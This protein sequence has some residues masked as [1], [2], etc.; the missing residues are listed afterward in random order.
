MTLNKLTIKQAQAKMEAG[1]ISS[2]DLTEACLARIKEI[3]DDVKACL[4]VCE[5]D[6]LEEARVADKRRAK[7][8]KGSL[9]GIPYLA[10]DNI[11]GT[12][13]RPRVK[14]IGQEKDFGFYIF[15]ICPT[16]VC[17]AEVR[18]SKFTV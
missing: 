6:A 1:E 8:E 16:E 18:T 13:Y 10:K 9:L 14:I 3:N 7:G 12:C 11:F 2:I 4:S 5:E 17:T 15:K